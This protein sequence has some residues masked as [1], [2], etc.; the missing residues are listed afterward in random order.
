MPFASNK[1]LPSSVKDALPSEAQSQFRAVVNSVLE[2][3]HSESQAFASAWA[4]IKRKWKKSGAKWIRKSEDITPA[5]ELIE[6]EGNYCCTPFKYEGNIL[7][8]LREDQVPR[9]LG[10][11][12]N[13]SDLPVK[14]VKV[15]ELVAIQN[16]VDR[17]KVERLRVKKAAAKHPVVV[18]H[19]GR[20]YI[21]DGHHRA[22]A[23]WLDGAETI[24]VHFKD[25]EEVTNMV[26]A[27]VI[28]KVDEELGLV[29]GWAI[30]SKVE[31]ED[32]F[33]TQGDH[34]PENAMLKASAEFMQNSRM[35]KEM[36]VGEGK[37][38][39]VFA[40]PMTEDIAKA[41][42]METKQTGL[43]IAMKPDDAEMVKKFKD[44]TYTGFSIGGKRIKDKELDD[45]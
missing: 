6:L 18:Q 45:A 10:A 30:V 21:A 5:R 35:A 37:G 44:G 38:S 42:G 26:K 43:M 22:T 19:D 25:L 8:S 39:V 40:F 20:L 11:L 23:K 29:F 24:D 41:M 4:V 15:S 3:G 14:S 36:H 33:D 12:T 34:I 31:G 28:A 27:D 13:A 32:Y 1:D 7:G 17:E 16:R 2:R 9:F